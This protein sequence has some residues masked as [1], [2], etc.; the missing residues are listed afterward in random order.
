MD[1]NRVSISDNSYDTKDEVESIKEA[2]SQILTHQCINDFARVWQD[3][4]LETN[5][6][7]DRRN[8]M[9]EHVGQLLLEMLEE[10]KTLKH[11]MEKSVQTCMDEMKQIEQELKLTS[12]HKELATKT[13]L[14]K[15]RL[16]R[17][18]VDALKKIKH[19]RMKRFKRLTEMEIALCHSLELKSE[20]SDKYQ[21]LA[22]PSEEELQ[23]YRKRVDHLESIKDQR[24]VEY[25]N[26]REKALGIWEE[27][28]TTP[29]DNIG[30]Q[31]HGGDVRN[32]VFSEQNMEKLERY[33]KKLEAVALKQEKDAEYLRNQIIPLWERLEIPGI[34]R[35]EFL[36]KH[37]G[38]K[39][40]MIDELQSELDRLNMLKR[41]NLER[42]IEATR[43]ELNTIW[44]KCLYGVNQKK[45]FRPA[46]SD[47]FTDDSLSAH[48]SELD[49]MRGFYAD[50]VE[51]FKLVEKRETMWKQKLEMEARAN[52]PNRLKNRGGKLL[53]EQRQ[54]QKLMKEF[55]KVEKKLKQTV[56][57]W[58][59]DH[60]RR[61]VVL[62]KPYL[63]EL[64][65]QLAN[66][67]LMKEQE[68]VKKQQ[69]KAEITLLEMKYGTKCHTPPKR[70]ALGTTS[71]ERATKVRR[72]G[73]SPLVKSTTTSGSSTG[74]KKR[75]MSRLTPGRKKLLDGLPRKILGHRNAP[76]SVYIASD[77]SSFTTQ[78]NSSL[79]STGSYTDFQHG[80]IQGMESNKTA[81]SST[82]SKPSN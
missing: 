28:E 45:E 61:F 69:S 26:I 71:N 72:V 11:K 39:T 35:E 76:S 29:S 60:C 14:E 44:D 74:P 12:S 70:K 51:V 79:A 40:W 49:R 5:H 77:E 55:P 21:T 33:F 54:E 46:F 65:N 41:D 82:I 22:V 6:R 56:T 75:T 18:R 17:E 68:K 36:S 15:E 23:G 80:L 31:L 1:T 10:E 24:Q 37:S 25:R 52:D 43:T 7:L 59:E 47:E 9:V 19:D 4:G 13:L 63:D 8:S 3:I 78:S 42:F 20:F 62:D 34:F 67:N 50:N 48:E 53:Q 66:Y 32:F 27:L 64:E 2:L 58:E 57:Q 30:I 73:P 16:V 81:R 38:Y